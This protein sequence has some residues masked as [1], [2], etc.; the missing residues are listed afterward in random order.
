MTRLFL[1]LY[2]FIALSLI[3]LSALLNH[4]F[5]NDDA[6]NQSDAALINSLT[7][8]QQR[9]GITAKDLD[10]SLFSVKTLNMGDM[11]WNAEELA[12]LEK[13][14][15]IVLFDDQNGTQIYFQSTD[16]KLLEITLLHN[17]TSS[18]KYLLYSGLFFFLLAGLIALWLWP[19]WKDLLQ[20]KQTATRIGPSGDFPP[21]DIER[22][23][24]VYPIAIALNDLGN[25]V[26]ELLNTQRELTGAV[27]HEFRTPL[28]R[29]KFAI[30]AHDYDE[31]G[32]WTEMNKDIDELEKLVQEMLSYTSMEVQQPE[33]NITEIP[34]LTLS[35]L[36]IA[37]LQK[38]IPQHIKIDIVGSESTILGDEHFIERVIDNL[39]NNASRYAH[40]TIKVDV[41][42]NSKGIL[43]RMEDDGL[44][45]PEIYRKRIFEPFF[46]PDN[47]RDRK[48]GGAGLGLAIIKR[49]MHWHQGECW[50]ENAE[51]GGASF[52]LL[53]KT[54][55]IINPPHN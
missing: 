4:V 13:Q 14:L 5:F 23:S 33:L 16:A 21:I 2:I 10:K 40:S 30:A 31:S 49:I 39:I 12:K 25:R 45:V 18:S 51:L 54:T 50:V 36:R 28:S 41:S 32:P 11:A 26:R 27:A 38:S 37:Y 34:L 17:Q 47:S 8:L 48:R 3:A 43:L 24:V 52:C 46:R 19:L 15:P 22:T 20:L 44:G 1:S 7:V 35:R 42:E 53:F 29:L 55:R 6:V 9:G